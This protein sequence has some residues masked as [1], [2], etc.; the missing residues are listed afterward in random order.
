MK[1][2]LLFSGRYLLPDWRNS[3]VKRD[4][5]SKDGSLPCSVVEVYVGTCTQVIDNRYRDFRS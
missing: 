2:D 4:L 5:F 3:K 1:E